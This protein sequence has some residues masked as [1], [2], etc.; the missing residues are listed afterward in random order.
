LEL[1]EEIKIIFLLS[2]IIIDSSDD[3]CFS[4]D[5]KGL[6]RMHIIKLF[7]LFYYLV[8]LLILKNLIY[9]LF[10]D[11]SPFFYLFDL[12]QYLI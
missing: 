7:F 3:N 11:V 2:F 5:K 12:N 4:K 1:F 8:L 6:Q 9:L 10:Y